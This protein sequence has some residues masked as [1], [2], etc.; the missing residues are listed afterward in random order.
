[1]VEDNDKTFPYQLERILRGDYGNNNVEVINAG[2]GGYDS[3]ES[4]INLQFRVLDI[5]PDL[6]IVYH[7]TNDVHTRLVLPD[8]YQGDNSGRRKQWNPPSISFIEYSL[9]LRI[10]SRKLGIMNQVSLEDFVN[11]STF[12]G[13]GGREWTILEGQAAE[14]L[15]KTH[16]FISGAT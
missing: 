5:D 4:L 9:L 11:A 3:W 16:R 8:A 2:V 15:Q 13:A 7:G 6:I 12:H 14:L 10:A 1:M